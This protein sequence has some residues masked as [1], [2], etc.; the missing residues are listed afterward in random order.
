MKKDFTVSFLKANLLGFLM[1]I[2]VAIFGVLY[3]ELWSPRLPGA[4]SG[5]FSNLEADVLFLAAVLVG[6]FVHELIHLA[7]AIYFGRIS[8]RDFRFGVD[9]KTLS[10]YFHC[11]V[12]LEVQVYRKMS[13]MPAVLLG[14]LPSIAGLA[15]GNPWI[16]LFGLLFVLASGGDLLI[17]W[18]IR[19]IKPGTMIEDHPNRVGCLVLEPENAA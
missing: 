14:L 12:P 9:P 10:P 6:V 3:F 17:L 16:M 18:L 8:S 2:P 11:K 1:L 19:N 5:L 15:G 13:A 7:S 4:I